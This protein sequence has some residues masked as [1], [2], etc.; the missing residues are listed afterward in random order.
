MQTRVGKFTIIGS[1]NAF[2][3]IR[4]QAIIWTNA[5]ILLIRTLGTNFS[6]ILIQIHTF[7]NKKMH[8]KMSAILFRP[9]SVKGKEIVE[10]L[11]K[12][13]LDHD[14]N[15]LTTV[16]YAD[17]TSMQL[18][19]GLCRGLLSTLLAAPLY[20]YPQCH[21]GLAPSR[22]LH[23]WLQ[24]EWELGQGQSST[25]ISRMVRQ[26][27]ANCQKRLPGNN[28]IFAAE[29]TAISLALNY[30]RYMGPVCLQAIEGKDTDNP[31]ICH[32]MNLLW[33]LNDKGTHVRFC[34]I[35][36]HCGIG[37]NKSKPASKK[38]HL[39]MT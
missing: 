12:G 33:L 36:S 6:E 27:A 35:P 14:I 24:N 29:A 19:A 30:Y 1:S 21:S 31:F 8:L 39:T 32:I 15:P 5:G 18:S 16:H 13:T 26:L 38:R 28:T 22:S 34:W 7:S 11:A 23:R 2:S 37:G 3:P 20:L 4:R 10:Q 17:V 9:Q 25:A